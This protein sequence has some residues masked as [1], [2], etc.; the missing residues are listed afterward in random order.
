MQT[1]VWE[2]PKVDTEFCLSFLG[3]PNANEISYL[4]AFLSSFIKEHNFSGVQIW[5]DSVRH[6][7][8][9]DDVISQNVGSYSL[10]DIV[11]M[12]H[13]QRLIKSSAE[14]A[15]MRKSCEIIA[16]SVQETMKV[17]REA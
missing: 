8:V 7:S 12:I 14:Q 3:I 6:S 16:S 2:G 15:L 11:P 5:R 1:E 17:S 4:P 10:V 9:I 13:Q